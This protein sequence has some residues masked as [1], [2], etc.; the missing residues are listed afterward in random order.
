MLTDVVILGKVGFVLP[1]TEAFKVALP[2]VASLK[3]CINANPDWCESLH[4]FVI[5]GEGCK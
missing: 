2:Q 5:M 1:S 3:G 4:T